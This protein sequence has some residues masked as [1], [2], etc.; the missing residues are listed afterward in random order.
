MPMVL[1]PWWKPYWA[2]GKLLS[3]EVV[4]DQ[5]FSSNGKQGNA[6][7]ISIVWL[8]LVLVQRNNGGVSKSV[9]IHSSYEMD[10]RMS[11]NSLKAVVLRAWYSSTEIPSA[12]GALPQLFFYGCFDRIHTFWEF[13]CNASWSTVGGK[14]R[15]WLKCSSY[16]ALISSLSLMMA[17]PPVDVRGKGEGIPLE[18]PQMAI[19]ALYSILEL[20]VSEKSCISPAF[21]PDHLS[22]TLRSSLWAVVWQSLYL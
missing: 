12:P 14:F 15:S 20:L 4:A 3:V 2:L 10:T 17:E 1:W 8:N 19:I 13:C 16:L 22:C 11:R 5:D 7:L 6:P 9:G 21:C 18:G